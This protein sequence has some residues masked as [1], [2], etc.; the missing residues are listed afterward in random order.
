MEVVPAPVHAT[1]LLGGVRHAG[2]LGERQGV[3]VCAQAHHG[4]GARLARD[5]GQ[6]ARRRPQVKE[7]HAI[8]ARE[9]LTDALGRAHL[10]EGELGVPV[11]VLEE[12]HQVVL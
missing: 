7:L 12:P 8:Y 1:L 9:H 3:Y 6:D 2:V 4:T 11:E 5:A 10:L